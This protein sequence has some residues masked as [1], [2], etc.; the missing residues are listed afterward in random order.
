[1]NVKSAVELVITEL[2]AARREHAPMASAHE[3]YALI[4]EE[5]DELWE[6]V[7]MRK[8]VPERLRDEAVQIAA[9]SIRFLVDVV[10]L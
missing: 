6:E 2:N 7:K 5:L 3:G 1:M 9:M 8:P 10:K 4:L